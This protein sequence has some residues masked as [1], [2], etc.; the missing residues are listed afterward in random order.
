MC[1]GEPTVCTQSSATL[2]LAGCLL[3]DKGIDYKVLHLN[4]ESCLG[5]MDDHTH[6]VTFGF[7][8]SD[9]CGMEVMVSSSKY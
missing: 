3:E 5:H 9:T 2:T 6:M 8:S 4:D 1:P 7:D